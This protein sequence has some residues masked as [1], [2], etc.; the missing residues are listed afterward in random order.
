MV[1]YFGELLQGFAFTQNG[2]VQSYGSRCVKP[3]IIYGDVQ[4]TQPMTVD[5]IGF[6]Q[7]CTSRPVKGMLTGPVTILS[8]SFV[9]DDQ[10]LE[11]TSL[12]IAFALRDE[13]CD[14][15][16]AGMQVIQI[17]EP[18][19]REALP[20]RK[21]QWQTYLKW[22]VNCF[23]VAS[24]GVKDET[25]IHTHMCYSEFNDIIEAIANLDA[26]V[27]TI[28]SSRSEMELFKSFESFAY[29]NE[30]GPGVYDIHSPRIPTSQE[31]EARLENALQFIPAERLWVNPDCGLKTRGWPEVERALDN[32]VK[33]AKNCRLKHAKQPLT[34]KT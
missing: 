6:A 29:P 28:E 14:L 8:W 25:Q 33:A 13:V 20:L 32:M 17:D 11:D 24:S 19:F 22:A 21:N 34:E 16:K 2:W 12:Q 4:R 30:I 7:S 5:W 26:D 15:E 27:I 23:R 18:A 10:P 3:P 9:R 1:E 31:I